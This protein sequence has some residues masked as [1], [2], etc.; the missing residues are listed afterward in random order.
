MGVAREDQLP[1]QQPVERD[2]AEGGQAGAGGANGNHVVMAE[3][4]DG[5][6]Q[7]DGGAVDDG[8]VQLA[9]VQP[10]DQVAAVALH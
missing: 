3:G 5:E 10:F 1:V 8:E 6:V 9:A 4:F 7:V 2:L